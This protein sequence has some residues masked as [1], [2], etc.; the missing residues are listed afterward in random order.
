MR[1]PSVVSSYCLASTDL[2]VKL[3]HRCFFDELSA[4]FER[5]SVYSCPVIICGDFNVHVDQCNDTHAMRLV[6]LLKSFGYVQH[7]NE[8]THVAGH[9]LDLVI[10]NRD[11]GI[12]DQK[13][14]DPISDHSLIY[15]IT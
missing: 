4:T 13:I 15:F 10:T 3:Y 6:Q 7:V 11:T 5:L 8:P 14:S 12:T 1:R 2:A 9:T